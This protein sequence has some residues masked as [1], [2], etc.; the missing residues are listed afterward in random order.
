MQGG[1][2]RD[3]NGKFINEY[4]EI[5]Y[6]QENNRRNTKITRRSL[7]CS[8]KN[9]EEFK[10]TKKTFNQFVRITRNDIGS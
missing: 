3:K 9:K 2:R 4:I 5:Q 10:N 1:I 7:T 8:Y 6:E